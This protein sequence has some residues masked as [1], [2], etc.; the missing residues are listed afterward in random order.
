MFLEWE[1]LLVTHSFLV[2]THPIFEKWA[3]KKKSLMILGSGL[4]CESSVFYSEEMILEE[5]SI[6]SW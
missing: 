1:D 6:V 2:S 5:K 4:L 3:E